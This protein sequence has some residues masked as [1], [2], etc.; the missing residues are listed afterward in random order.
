MRGDLDLLTGAIAARLE[1]MPELQVN[2]RA[3]RRVPYESVAPV[4]NAL[5]MA[6]ARAGRTEGV[7]VNLVIQVDQDA[8]GRD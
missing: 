5:A 7:R 2:L 3:D 4:M 6:G 8:G 1:V